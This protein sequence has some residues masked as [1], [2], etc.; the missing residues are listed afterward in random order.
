MIILIVLRDIL[1]TILRYYRFSSTSDFK[2]SFIAKR[3]T[4]VQIIIIHLILILHIIDPS[5]IVNNEYLY[6]MVLLSVL[7]SW[8]SAFDY[9]LSIKK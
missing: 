3:K 1:V 8:F 5:Y 6:Y 2:T 7:L 4:L 9:I